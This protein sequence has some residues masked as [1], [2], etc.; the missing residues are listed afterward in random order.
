MSAPIRRIANLAFLWLFG[1]SAASA[2]G[3]GSGVNRESA[4]MAGPYAPN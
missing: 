1:A 2:L 4:V 3:D